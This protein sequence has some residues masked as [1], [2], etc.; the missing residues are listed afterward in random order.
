MKRAK[1]FVLTGMA[2]GFASGLIVPFDFGVRGAIFGGILAVG[3]L[4]CEESREKKGCLPVRVTLIVAVTVSL[5]A[6]LLM[7]GWSFI[8]RDFFIDEIFSFSNPILALYTSAVGSFLISWGMFLCY[9]SYTLRQTEGLKSLFFFGMP[10]LSVI[11]RT[12]S[13]GDL[14]SG[15]SLV[16]VS[17]HCLAFGLLPFLL[18]WGL[19]ARLFGFFRKKSYEEK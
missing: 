16:T 14:S 3:M 17:L 6:A 10:L 12:A 18:L 8:T 9:R 7:G 19:V 2:A 13:F 1:W 5:V 11:P 4:V 15:E